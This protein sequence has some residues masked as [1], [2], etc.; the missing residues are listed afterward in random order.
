MARK[1]KPTKPASAYT[2]DEIKDTPIYETL[3]A[4]LPSLSP[5]DAVRLTRAELDELWT[6]QNRAKVNKLV[7]SFRVKLAALGVEGKTVKI[8]TVTDGHGHVYYDVTTEAG[9]R[10]HADNELLPKGCL[11]QRVIAL[12]D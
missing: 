9:G 5:R 6:A 2:V 10:R 4:T 1:T 11:K 12:E 8:V 7:D 3:V